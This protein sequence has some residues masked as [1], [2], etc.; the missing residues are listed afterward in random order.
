MYSCPT[1]EHNLVLKLQT[2]R[3]IPLVWV[4]EESFSVTWR[5]K[6]RFRLSH[7]DIKTIM[8]IVKERLN[9][10]DV[11]TWRQVDCGH[12]SFLPLHLDFV[13]NRNNLRST[14]KFGLQIR[15][16]VK[17]GGKVTDECEKNTR[18]NCYDASVKRLLWWLFASS[19]NH[20]N[21]FVFIVK[22]SIYTFQIVKKD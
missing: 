2:Y 16:E 6:S 22:Y 20:Q 5:T 13:K 11:V 19:S 1:I 15:I 4:S 7:L 14:L 21:C 12:R 3:I 10:A 9:I 8:M 17:P 18:V